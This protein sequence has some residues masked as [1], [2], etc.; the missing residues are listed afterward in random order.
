LEAPEIAKFKTEQQRKDLVEEFGKSFYKYCRGALGFKDMSEDLHLDF[1]LWLQNLPLGSRF[2]VAMSRGFL[3]S[4]IGTLGFPTWKGLYIP[5]FATKLVEQK[6]DNA[7]RNHFA[8]IVEIFRNSDRSDYLQ[9]LYQDRLPENLDGWN[10]NQ[11]VF[12]RPDPLALPAITYGGIDSAQEGW[13]GDMVLGDDLEG[14]D[15]EKRLVHPEDAWRFV[16][17][18]ATPLLKD[19]S[20]GYI[21]VIGTPHGDNPLVHRLR[22]FEE[23]R[24][25]K[26]KSRI[27]NIYWKEA[28]DSTGQS[29]WPE[30]FPLKV[31]NDIKDLDPGLFDQ[32]YMLLKQRSS[33]LIFDSRKV[34][35]AFYEW[36]FAPDHL[37]YNRTEYNPLELDSDGFP[38]KKTSR[39]TANVWEMRRYI[40]CDPAH[41]EKAK[42]SKS[43]GAIAVIGVN[44]DSHAF[45]LDT[46][47]K[48]CG[49]EEFA[50]KVYYMYRKWRPYQVVM[51]AIGAQTW[52]WDY[53]RLLE[54]NKYAEIWAFPHKMPG[55]RKAETVLLPRLATPYKLIEADKK[56]AEKEQWVIS[57]LQSW[58]NHGTLHMNASQEQLMQ[59]VRSFPDPSGLK[60]LLDCLAQGPSVWKAPSS[61]EEYDRIQQRAY[62]SQLTRDVD[63]VTGYAPPNYESNPFS[64]I[65]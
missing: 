50:E 4:S 24:A 11:I 18:R 20:T 46:W 14:A 36:V 1:C 10:T 60:D 48:D 53:A 43:E 52:F 34:T 64:I 16:T 21:G 42:H 22:E 6:S 62:V 51:E 63:P 12:N 29:R 17:K 37:S 47:A 61:P 49:L 55:Q 38:E 13:H 7:Y 28:I 56:N 41:K 15:A 5:N 58:F 40:Q 54:K 44:W 19:P 45:V 2:M 59:Q 8:P 27:W 32:Q 39:V 65:N 31:L 35:K 57:Q 23:D 33:D 30:R 25:S 9:W 3:K 26:G